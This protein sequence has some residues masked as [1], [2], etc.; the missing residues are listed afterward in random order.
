MILNKYNNIKILNYMGDD[1][2]IKNKSISVLIIL[3]MAISFGSLP[4][5]A[6]EEINK[7]KNPE[8]RK[9]MLNI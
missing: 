3:S 8:T 6:D 4:V 1:Y 7:V 9:F 2:M 5:Y